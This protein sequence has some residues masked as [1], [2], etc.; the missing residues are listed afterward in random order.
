MLAM[1]Y[2]LPGYPNGYGVG[3]MIPIAYFSARAFEDVWFKYIAR[4]WRLRVFVLLIPLMVTSQV[5]VLFAPVSSYTLSAT[6][7]DSPLFL[8]RDY[9]VA[10][11]WLESQH[12]TTLSNPEIVLASPE[13]S[14][15]V[16]AWTG[17]QVVYGFPG[18]TLNPSEKYAAVL[19]WF[20]TTDSADCT[21]LL[22]GAYT[23]ADPYT[24]RFVIYGPE[25][26]ELGQSA[27]LERLLPT[28]SF[29]EVAIYRYVRGTTPT[30]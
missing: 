5:I 1:M 19:D 26:R 15:W 6:T 16:P 2:L 27:C 21:A 18:G 20:T 28:V 3:M 4:T 30:P 25:E 24:V 8:S 23:D 7:P 9:L 14:V 22:E 29:G 11:R 13:V 17:M 10:L 12:N